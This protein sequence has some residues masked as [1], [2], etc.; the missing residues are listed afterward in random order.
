MAGVDLS[1]LMGGEGVPSDEDMRG[2]VDDNSADN[3][4]D[5]DAGSLDIPQNTLELI[6]QP[7]GD[8]ADDEGGDADDEGGDAPKGRKQLV[9]LGA[10]QEERNKRQ[11]LQQQLLERDQRQQQLNDR[12][13]RLLEAQQLAQNPPPEPEV[14]PDFDDDPRGHVNGLR[15][16][17]EQQMQQ[18]QQL[19]GGQQQNTQ[20]AQYFQQVQ[21]RVAVDEQT[22]RA[23]NPDYNEAAQFFNDRKLAEYAALGLDPVAARQQLAKDV[24][25]VAQLAYQQ[26]KNPAEVL[27]NLAKAFGHTPGQGG[28]QLAPGNGG[29]NGAPPAKQPLTSLSSLEGASRAPD[30]K[31]KLTAAQ[32]AEMSDKDFDALWNDMAKKSNTNRIKI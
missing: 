23:T 31:G 9:P 7:G 5:S 11:E 2:T 10:L 1:D 17:F 32:V 27:H 3:S 12:L 28:Q 15:R 18:M 30:E 8:D 4:A 6:E 21:S 26:N 22:Y 19:L 16:Q 24:F 14:I 29:N 20:Q 25:G 13:T